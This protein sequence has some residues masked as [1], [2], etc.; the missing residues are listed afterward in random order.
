VTKSVSNIKSIQQSV[1]PE[2]DEYLEVFKESNSDKLPDH[3]HY[4]HNIP[5]EGDLRP[6]FGPIYSLSAV[7]LK[8]LDDYLKENLEQ[9]FFQPGGFTHPLCQEI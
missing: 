8:A 9:G 2:F 3:G 7:E 4:D 1:P 6:P 5:L